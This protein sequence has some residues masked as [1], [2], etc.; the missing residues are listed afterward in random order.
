MVD[1]SVKSIIS[2]FSYFFEFRVGVHINKTCVR[3]F[4][5]QKCFTV[6]TKLIIGSDYLLCRERDTSRRPASIGFR[7]V[8]YFVLS[9]NVVIAF[10]TSIGRRITLTYVYFRA[11][12]TRE[13]SFALCFDIGVYITYIPIA[14]FDIGF[15][16]IG[17][18]LTVITFFT[19]F[20]FGFS[21]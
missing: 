11:V 18:I 2:Y 21:V 10:S 6:R 14:I 20:T 12:F 3:V 16:S 5:F 7:S 13:P 15:R 8:E 9:I 19:F 1:T 4:P 17:S